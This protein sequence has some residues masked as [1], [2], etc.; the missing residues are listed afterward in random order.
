MDPEDCVLVD[1]WIGTVLANISRIA[2]NIDS[3]A[4][5]VECEALVG[6]K[7]NSKLEEF[8]EGRGP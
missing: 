8:I 7:L 5:L 6:G 4:G 1:E 3:V 2:I